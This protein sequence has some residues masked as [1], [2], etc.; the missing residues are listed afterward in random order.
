[1]T[2]AIA[3][4]TAA[5]LQRVALSFNGGTTYQALSLDHLH[6]ILR[7]IGIDVFVMLGPV[8]AGSP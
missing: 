6:L 2:P 3:E 1:M 4:Q 7:Q 5:I 8:V